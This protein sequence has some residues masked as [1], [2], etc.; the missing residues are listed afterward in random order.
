MARPRSTGLFRSGSFRATAFAA[1]VSVTVAVP[2]AV[3]WPMAL[4]KTPPQVFEAPQYSTNG[5][6]AVFYE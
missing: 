4:L 6:R 1:A 2:A 5:V 3:Q